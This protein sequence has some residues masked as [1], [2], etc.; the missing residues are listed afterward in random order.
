MLRALGVV[1]AVLLEFDFMHDVAYFARV[2]SVFSLSSLRIVHLYIVIFFD[3]SLSSAIVLLR[4]LC[5][6]LLDDPFSAALSCLTYL[7]LM[8]L[9]LHFLTLKLIK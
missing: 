3:P 9:L 4:S 1:F 7:S 6:L 5:D 8:L 2:F